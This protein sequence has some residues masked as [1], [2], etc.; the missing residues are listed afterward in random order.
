M[1]PIRILILEDDAGMREMLANV[2]RAQGYEV[3]AVGK[4][5]EAVR[6]AM[7]ESFDVIVADIRMEGMDG[8]DTLARVKEHRPDIGS[9]VVTGY[10]TEADSI[11]AIRLGVGDY[12]KKPFRLPTFLASVEA[13]VARRRQ[14]QRTARQL[15]R[16]E[17]LASWGVET[18]ARA[19][20][21]GREPESLPFEGV[22]DMAELAVR[23]AADLGADADTCEAVHMAA[24][25]EGISR[26]SD[27]LH[28]KH[29]GEVLPARVASMIENLEERWDGEG[30]EGLPGEAIP[31]GSRILAVL[32]NAGKG[33]LSN[34]AELH[35]GAFD[36]AVLAALRRAAAGESP[37]PREQASHARRRQGLL[38]L[39]R[40]LEHGGHYEAAGHAYQQ[41]LTADR[42]SREG[43]EALLGL[44]RLAYAR[45]GDGQS[46]ALQ[47]VEEARKLGPA[48]A[49]WATLEAT[50]LLSRRGVSEPARTLC[51]E[52]YRLFQQMR[53][54]VGAAIT[55][56]VA[57]CFHGS[58]APLAPAFEVLLQ[59]EYADELA[60]H[61]D[62]MIPFLLE[63]EASDTDPGSQRLLKRFGR[64]FPAG[65]VRALEDGLS[66]GARRAAAAALAG[67]AAPAA[68][69][70][71]EQLS[72]DTEE[73]VRQA[74]QGALQIGIE[75]PPPMLRLYSLGP[76]EVYKGEERV[77]DKEWKSQKVRYLLAML[78]AHRGRPLSEDVLLETFWPGD[79]EKGRKNLYA[80]T[81][82]LRR[83]LRPTGWK[84]E[85]DYVVRSPAG[86]TLNPDLPCWHDLD[87]L[88]KA[89]ADATR[90]DATPD[91]VL[92]SQ[93]R[94]ARLYRGPYLE[95]SYLD[96]ALDLRNRL[97]L[98]VL[99]V[100]GRLAAETERRGQHQEALEHSQRVLDLDPCCQEAHL[101]R[102]R[103]FLALR[104]PE[105][106]VRQFQHCRDV[107][108][109]ELDME[110]APPLVNLYQQAV[111]G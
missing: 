9:L 24:M 15:R 26:C 17:R 90:P 67:S 49:G 38:S 68:E 97:E 91:R 6:R 29:P 76:F 1:E 73:S 19:V 4:G 71:L 27:L 12:L 63:K 75:S 34:L 101:I 85:L 36:P 40:T 62:W 44:A 95:G 87:E 83:H 50:L 55:R 70:C 5:E 105:E 2:V 11:R 48:T 89:L 32:L 28:G 37:A 92:D 43:V 69:A 103:A 111:K 100:L 72:A 107:L 98:Q 10:S 41:L 88:E 39:A 45:G 31:L 82:Y 30:P 14:E 86:L 3:E 106:A 16:A 54:G 47:A 58:N 25:V 46:E 108:N 99:D 20:D 18:A 52:A 60:V 51:E 64:E 104:R 94:V 65:F 61:G 84:G 56:M 110:P 66:S 13:V 35:P 7:A 93:R 74:A 59:P 57:A 22:V 81:S 8:L 79:P 21:R 23:V 78:A 109:E 102:M 53:L 77:A 80:A 42:A 96:W 33:T